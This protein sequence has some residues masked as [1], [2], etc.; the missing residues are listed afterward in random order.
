MER[1]TAAFIDKKLFH[2]NKINQKNRNEFMATSQFV[3]KRNLTIFLAKTIFP[4]GNG[5]F[6][7]GG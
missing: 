1:I 7:T 2:G 5:N 6:F 4:S 3:L